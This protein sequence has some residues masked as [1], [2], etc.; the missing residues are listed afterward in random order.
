MASHMSLRKKQWSG[1]T[2]VDLAHSKMDTGSIHTDTVSFIS[3]SI[4]NYLQNP[5]C[6]KITSTQLSR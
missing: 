6:H 2:A 3:M 1:Q 4:T 5:N